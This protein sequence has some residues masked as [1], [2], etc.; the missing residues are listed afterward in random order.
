MERELIRFTVPLIAIVFF[1]VLGISGMEAIRSAY[2]ENV[3]KFDENSSEPETVGNTSVSGELV[4]NGFNMEFEPVIVLIFVIFV[5]IVAY[6]TFKDVLAIAFGGSFKK[7]ELGNYENSFVEVFTDVCNEYQKVEG[8]TVVNSLLDFT[9]KIAPLFKNR[10]ESEVSQELNTVFFH[11][12]N[13]LKE[14]RE[15]IA[16][17]AELDNPEMLSTLEL[18]VERLE[19]GYLEYQRELTQGVV[20]EREI[21]S[22]IN[23]NEEQLKALAND[24]EK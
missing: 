8:H 19:K 4:G 3:T 17:G 22:N 9:L 12:T 6:S 14:L 5:V 15:A 10:E 21:L 2:V 18:L 16:N 1:L 11:E 24:L 23:K 13:T 20:Y 7:I